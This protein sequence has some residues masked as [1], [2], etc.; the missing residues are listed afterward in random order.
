MPIKPGFF[1]VPLFNTE[2]K[3][4]VDKSV[5]ESDSSHWSSE[6]SG[7]KDLRVLI[8]LHAIAPFHM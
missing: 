4:S 8:L 2:M 5:M 6:G 7:K 1:D 3:E